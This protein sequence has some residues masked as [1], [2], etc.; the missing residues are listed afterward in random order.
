M[1]R[2]L[3]P[4]HDLI[5]CIVSLK[6]V[7]IKH[8]WVNKSLYHDRIYFQSQ[9][10]IG[11]VKHLCSKVFFNNLLCALMV[12]DIQ[13]ATMDNSASFMLMQHSIMT[14]EIYKPVF[15]DLEQLVI[16]HRATHL[17]PIFKYKGV[18]H[19]HRKHR[20]QATGNTYICFG[21]QLWGLDKC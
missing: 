6:K 15:S 9:I 20:P 2:C 17:P 13:R 19:P 4:F 18:Q 14:D 3:T 1:R 16:P 10:N 21:Y 11:K 12:Y 7:N 8:M 5:G